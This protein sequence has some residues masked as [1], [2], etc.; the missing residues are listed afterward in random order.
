MASIKITFFLFFIYSATLADEFKICENIILLDGKIKLNGNEKILI[1]GEDDGP[2]GWKEIPVTQAELHLRA[3]FQNLG[4]LQP[5]FER[6]ANRLLVWQG[7][8]TPIKHLIVKGAGEIL[9]TSKKRKTVGE[10]LTP[11]K[12]NEVEAWANLGIRSRGH[13]CPELSVTAHGWNG[14]VT[15]HTKLDERKKFG[16]LT[17]DSLHGLNADVL[18]RYQPFNS[19]DW[20]DIRKTQI[21]S[22]RLLADGLFQSAFFE[23]TCTHENADLELKTTTGPPR[24]VRFGIGASTEE[25]PFVDI[26]FRNTRLD[27]Q[28]SSVTATFHGSPRKL[29]LTADSELYWF[30]GWH[31]SFFAPR[32]EVMR[33]IESAYQADS[34]RLGADLGI[35]WDIWNTRF[36]GR[37]G[38][39][40]NSIKTTR[41][42]GPTSSYPSL[43]A[44]L[45]LMSHVYEGSLWQ[46]YEGWNA[47]L[48]FS[49]QGKGL[50]SEVD[51]N[52]Y[53]ANYK[54]LWNIQGFDPP[55]FI[56]GTRF[57]SIFVD[58][59][60][61]SNGITETNIPTSDR[62][63]VGGDQNLRGFPR[64]GIDNQG[65]G[66]LTFLYLGFEL[67]LIEELPYRLQPFLLWDLGQTGNKRY[68]VDPTLFIS[69]GIGLR[70]LSPFG[71]LRG[72][73]ARGRVLYYEI[74]DTFVP[75]QW[76]YFISFGQE[77]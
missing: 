3:I 51:V 24:I 57:Q 46:Q 60:D 40:L 54:Y 36:L 34:V 9:D 19:G 6:Q 16:L 28:A 56:L 17:F 2:Q 71:T 74:T 21:M 42:A 49:G 32:F 47:S 53:E 18:K 39:A 12:L 26:S 23:K 1:C 4:Y 77:F 61:L 22:D 76:V 66:Y 59:N 72:S 14:E 45:V 48:F 35:K 27:D 75:E 41:G 69:E 20:Y 10:T 70:W 68:T 52:R 7:Q 38:P 65:L 67:R 29:R 30:R 37:G 43:D 13:A 58:A 25:L 64:K 50:G 44:S 62:V 15:V 8:R 5:R 55:L 73:I 31:R 33:E 11:A 63:F